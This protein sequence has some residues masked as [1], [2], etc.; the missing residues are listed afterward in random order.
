M[1]PSE[2]IKIAEDAGII[3]DI[4]KWVIK[5]TIDQMDQWQAEGIKVNTA[6]NISSKDL[7]ND[8]I[9]EYTINCMKT[10][11]LGLDFLEFELTERTIV[12]NED[13]LCHF[14][15]R[16]KEIGM[17]ISLDDFGTGNN[18]L[19]HLAKL[20]IDY[21]KIDK[22]FIDHILNIQNRAIVE[23]IICLAHNLRMEV[24]AEGVETEEQMKLLKSMGCDYIQGYYFSKPLPPEN[25]KDFILNFGK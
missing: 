24:I 4:T 3:N 11:Q 7:K 13:R 8:S 22:V 21:I 19:I 17:K 14:L 16:L 9:I 5:N 23:G 6:I 20:P 18:S 10:H 25:L 2:F 1:N 12:E 15:D